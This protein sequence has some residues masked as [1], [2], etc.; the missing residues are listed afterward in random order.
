MY[1][2]YI[3]RFSD[4]VMSALGLVVLSP[5]L[6]IVCIL[7]R[8]KLGSPVL[9]KQDRAGKNEKIFTIYKFRSM[10]NAKDE[11]GNLL[12]D[13]VRLTKFGKWL[14]STSI[15]ELPE[16]WNI[17]K[18]DM[19]VVGPRPLLADYLPYYSGEEKRRHDVRPG[20]TGLAQVNGRNMV[21]WDGRLK[22][23]VEYISGVRFSADL[24]IILKTVKIVLTRRGI[25]SGNSTIIEVPEPL[26]N[27]VKVVGK[28]EPAGAS[29]IAERSMTPAP[30][31][32]FAN[33]G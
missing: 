26:V 23:D 18:G 30:A 31:E 27:R 29:V 17:I 19:S 3:K 32:D 24:K 16:L 5:V 4:V 1:N 25:S 11:N 10:T 15:D 9:F 6:L 13:E 12:P 7:V 2:K 14:R 8:I 20:L 28:R 33:V 21:D 22:Y